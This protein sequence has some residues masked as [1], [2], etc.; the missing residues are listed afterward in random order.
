MEFQKAKE[1]FIHSWS[2]LSNSWGI[3]KT[4]AQ[5]HALLLLS[6]KALS[7]EDIMHELNISR[8]NANM[9]IRSLIDW[10]IVFKSYQPNERKEYFVAEKDL[11]EVSKQLIQERKKRELDPLVKMLEQVQL[12][13]NDNSDEVKEFLKITKSVSEFQSKTDKVLKRLLKFDKYWFLGTFTKL[14]K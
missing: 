12:L 14:L 8:G 10:N 7:T 1:D 11:W 13:K 6:P 9:N 2:T 5:I 3:N 4:M